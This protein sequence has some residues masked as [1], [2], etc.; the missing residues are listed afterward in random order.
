[1]AWSLPNTLHTTKFFFHWFGSM[2][3]TVILLKSIIWDKFESFCKLLP[4]RFHVEFWCIRL[5]PSC[6]CVHEVSGNIGLET[7]QK[8]QV[9]IGMIRTWNNVFWVWKLHFF[10]VKQ[11]QRTCGHRF[12]ASPRL[13]DVLIDNQNLTYVFKCSLTKN[14]QALTWISWKSCSKGGFL[15]LQR[16][17]PSYLNV[18]CNIDLEISIFG[19]VMLISILG[20]N[21]PLAQ[22]F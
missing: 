10:S 6:H 14:R 5:V 18:L 3:W 7:P 15:G 11:R 1:M 4:S 21:W 17:N 22:L 2:F 20:W 8:C 19:N 12:T 9:F 16:A 13:T